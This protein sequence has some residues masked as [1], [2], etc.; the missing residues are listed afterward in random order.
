MDKKEIEL[1]IG[2]SP[3]FSK[4]K[5]RLLRKLIDISEIKEYKSAEIIYKQASCA[6][7]LYFFLKGR[8]AVLTQFGEKE[9]E[10]EIIKRGTCFGI[11]S[12]F[13]DASHSVTVKSIETSFILQIDKDNFKEFLEK[14]PL[15]ALDF[16]RLL[17]ERVTAR[18]KPKSI[19][20]SKRI[21]VMGS[22]SS[23]KTTYMID[24]ARQLKEQTGKKVI[25][26]QVLIQDEQ[27]LDFKA[28]GFLAKEYNNKIL[29]LKDFKEVSLSDFILNDNID[30]LYLKTES[31]EN[32]SSLLNFL[33]ESY[34]FI[35]YEV[36][37]S[38][39]SDYLNEF[40]EPA[41]QLHFFLFPDKQELVEGEALIKKLKAKNLLNSGKIKVILSQIYGLDNLSFEEKQKSLNHPIYATVLSRNSESYPKIVQ[42]IARQIG[43]VVLGLALGSGA[44]Y[45][46][47]HIGVLKVL[48]RNNITVDIICGTSMGAIVAALWAAGYSISDI[49]KFANE[50]GK[51]VSS[52]SIF[53][54]ALP[55]KGFIKSR[56]LEN[57]FKSIFKDLTFHD[58]KHSLKIVAFDFCRRKTVVLEQGYIYKAVAASCAFPGIFEPIKLQKNILLDGGILNPL[59]TKI[60]LQYNTYKII[61]SNIMLSPEQAL[62][63]YNKRDKFY[64]F[65]FIF[66]SV[67]T[68]QQR[69][70]E[71]AL[72]IADVTVHTD[73]E[74][75]GWMEFNKISEFI[76]RGEA[77]A[78]KEIEKIKKLT[79]V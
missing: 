28:E 56:R 42:R 35:L 75:L 16:S 2:N 40:T 72:K 39:L 46:F 67:E 13:T 52:F 10:I 27:A 24:L 68:M 15:T 76:K 73:L 9:K 11:I 49:E 5:K 47:S 70:V 34:H 6:D 18:H 12:L 41:H 79:A 25:V 21:G 71:D 45:G 22:I 59:P 32:F 44:A 14:N 77:A 26:V 33:S 1:I 78:E 17:S 54:V 4:L 51:K 58:L 19:F 37:Q 55:F 64:I 66:G 53:G 23:G 30:Y 60:L 65:D 36:P 61:A 29:A 20:Q 63:E 62:R 7:Y 74:G 38:F 31:G 48:E 50:F 43:E 8:A 57:I 69:F 3:P